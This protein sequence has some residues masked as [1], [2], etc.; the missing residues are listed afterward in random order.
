MTETEAYDYDL[1]EE[2]IAQQPLH[3]RADARLLVVD[4]KAESIG[5][6]HVRDLPEILR[7]GDMLVLNNSRVLPAR[8]VGFRTVT[9]GRW[10]GLYLE[11]GPN[12]MWRMLGKTRGKIGPSETVTLVDHHGVPGIT[13][14][15][16]S[17]LEGSVWI[18]RPQSD[19]STPA[20][21]DQ[22]GRVPLPPYIR[23]GEM[24]P[25]DT[26]RYQTTFADPPGSVAAPTAGLHF[27]PK[28]LD[29]LSERGV[30][31]GFVTLHVGVGTFRPIATA[32]LAE[33]TMHSEWCELPASTAEKIRAT[34][35]AGGRIVAV[36]TTSVRTLESAAAACTEPSPATLN[37][38]SGSTDLFIQPGYSFRVVDALL[39]NFHLPKSTL[40]VLVRA[41]GGDR[42]IQAA[43]RQ[44]IE[45]EYRFYSYGD[46]MLIC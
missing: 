21:L 2:L 7:T 25:S 22:F 31:R 42:L 33:H 29:S 17:K 32:S 40:L 36:G 19:L 26:D 4:R 5:H 27:T 13:L 34:Q 15:L 37:A 38:W 39:T 23:N 44:A 3:H 28:L 8:L 12:G 45:E 11:D 18:A 9:R 6:Y 30:E 41:F 43:Y 46:A 24:V 10:Q 20:I 1:P 14:E 35:A 16:I